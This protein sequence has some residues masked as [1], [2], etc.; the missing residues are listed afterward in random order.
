VTG[1]DQDDSALRQPLVEELGVGDR[2]DPVVAAVDDRDRRCDLRQ[3]LG[4][5]G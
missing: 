3:Q 1:I 2:D 5:L 4:K